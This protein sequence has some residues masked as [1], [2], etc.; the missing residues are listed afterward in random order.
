MKT[1]IKLSLSVSTGLATLIAAILSGCEWSGG[2]GAQTYSGRYN[3]LNFSG[4]YRG[5]N[6]GLLVTDYTKT[7]GNSTNLVTGETLAT[8]NGSKT[9][10]AGSLK[11]KSVLPGSLTISI[12]PIYTLNDT[13]GNGTM[14][15]TPGLGG[16]AA[17]VNYDTGAW[18]ITLPF[19]VASGDKIQATYL[20]KYSASEGGSGGASGS[21]GKAIYS[22][23]VEHFGNLI[24]LVDN[25]G[26][27]YEG[28]FGD[29][30]STGGLNQNSTT[31]TVV[32][33]ESFIGNFSVEGVSAANVKVKIVGTLNGKVGS[34]AGSS[35]VLGSRTMTGNWV[36]QGGKVG[37]VSGIA[38]DISIATP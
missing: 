3:F 27:V 18:S 24:K 2:G 12:P 36:E 30:R 9:A 28:T 14:S 19:A 20:S 31:G 35:F 15:I 6:G 10:F 21:S 8:G 26:S 32:A 29:I 16:V 33:G 38:S 5:I 13:D 23:N 17:L 34:V 22:F 4:V 1:K 7:G 37:D 25:N 11:G